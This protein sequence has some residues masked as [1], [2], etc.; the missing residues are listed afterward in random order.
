MNFDIIK[1]LGTKKENDRIFHKLLILDYFKSRKHEWLDVKTVEDYLV[2]TCLKNSL[3]KRPAGEGNKHSRVLQDMLKELRV[4]GVNLL[5][6]KKDGYKFIYK[7]NEH[8]EHNIPE[9]IDFKP[10]SIDAL[11]GWEKVFE[12]YDYLPLFDELSAF[13]KAYKN[14]LATLAEMEGEE[15]TLDEAG[16]IKVAEFE[17]DPDFINTEEDKDILHA[18]YYSIEDRET[19]SFKYKPFAQ[20]NRPSRTQTVKNF[21]PYLLKE[22]N[23]RWYLIG[24]WDNSS[25]DQIITYP[26]D[27]IVSIDNKRG[28]G[29]K[30]TDFNPHAYW[31][32]SMGIYTSW[33][34]IKGIKR[35]DPIPISFVLSD[36]EVFKNIDY[37]KSSRIH[38]S[39]EISPHKDGVWVELNIYPDSD[40]V[41]KLRSLGVHNLSNITPPFLDNWVRNV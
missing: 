11:L 16:I 9:T 18:L 29:F 6:Q 38:A 40:L 22:H 21:Y 39:Q 34:D 5:L 15:F 10:G 13:I 17:S 1:L 31:Q 36:G 2:D 41:R 14:K 24:K 27:R 32:H 30:R 20:A 4:K 35:T 23:K 26:C 28:K 37:L 12:K 19:V 7:Y 25:K 3:I 33:Q 8:N